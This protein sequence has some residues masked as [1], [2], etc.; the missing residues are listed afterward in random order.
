MNRSIKLVSG[1]T[2]VLG[3]YVITKVINI[4]R[5]IDSN[6]Y[7]NT[8]DIPKSFDRINNSS[9]D[10]EYSI[11]E[12]GNKVRSSV[13]EINT[14]N[15][16]GTGFV[17]DQDSNQTLILTNSHVVNNKKKL[18]VQWLDNTDDLAELVFDGRGR[19]VKNDLAL[20]RININKGT[21]LKLNHI[22]P[23]VG[24]EVLAFGWPK[25][26]GF[27]LTRGIISGIRDNGNI[28]QT[29][30]AINP[31]NSGGPLIDKTGCV[32]GINTFIMKETEGL[33]FAISSKAVKEFLDE[34]YNNP[35]KSRFSIKPQQINNKSTNKTYKVKKTSK[36]DN[37][38]NITSEIEQE[39]AISCPKNL[40][41]IR[42]FQKYISLWDELALNYKD[43]DTKDKALN[44]IRITCLMLSSPWN[45]E[46]YSTYL[47][48]AEAKDFLNDQDGTIK[49]LTMSIESA[50]ENKKSQLLYILAS[51]KFKYRDFEGGCYN[52]IK[53]L[54]KGSSDKNNYR[55]KFCN[56]PEN[57]N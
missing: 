36:S 49:D 3:L 16:N 6:S 41:L 8:T 11:E 20:I 13:V 51:Y 31:G 27:T 4:Q 44:V 56:S 18:L 22:K 46:K 23:P 52:L 14:M 28:I 17:I 43:V 57:Y 30:A 55:N 25:G 47:K 37:I 24:R 26:V 34:Y 1:I 10:N 7:A 38:P 45:N 5:T 40:T 2:I 33:N 39:S 12:L 54:K 50:N 9:C 29:D 35:L 19:T 32:I 15:G 53:A 42:N 48:R 21:K